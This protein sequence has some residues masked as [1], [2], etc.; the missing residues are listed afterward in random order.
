MAVGFVGCSGA[1]TTCNDGGPTISR[2][3][4][5][6]IILYFPGAALCVEGGEGW[7]MLSHTLEGV[8]LKVNI[9]HVIVLK[10]YLGKVLLY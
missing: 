3:F 2:D 5:L 8:D 1:K 9:T 6:G 4:K 7:E 10:F